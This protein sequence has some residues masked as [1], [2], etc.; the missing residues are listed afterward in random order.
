MS[1]VARSK[2]NYNDLYMSKVKWSNEVTSIE[3]KCQ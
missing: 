1:H 3:V 2:V